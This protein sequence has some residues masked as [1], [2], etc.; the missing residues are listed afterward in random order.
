MQ[1]TSLLILCQQ[2]LFNRHSA[3]SG[4][5]HINMHSLYAALLAQDL[6]HPLPTRFINEQLADV[7]CALSHANQGAAHLHF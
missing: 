3:Q 6:A 5:Q 4:K 1:A 2:H 7:S